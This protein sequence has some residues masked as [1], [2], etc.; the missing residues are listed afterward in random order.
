[1][2]VPVP[3]AFVAEI[4]NVCGPT[5]KLLP[6]Q[7]PWQDVAGPPSKLQVTVAD[8][9]STLQT[10]LPLFAFD[11]GGGPWV[12]VTIGAGGSGD[13]TDQLAV[14][15][16]VP[17][18]FVAEIV[19]VCDPTASPV[20]D[21]EPEHAAAL[22]ASRLQV[23]VADGSSTVNETVAVVEVVDAAGAESTVTMGAGGIGAATDQL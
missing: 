16:V 13:V 12:T 15:V 9:S 5:E 18:A 8:G 2:A 1:V 20:P 17:P 14:R 21:H 11:E 6:D 7:F 3:P 22:P 23:T 19:N 10:T 4:V